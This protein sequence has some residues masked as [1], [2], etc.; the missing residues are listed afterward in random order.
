MEFPVLGVDLEKLTFYYLI[1]QEDNETI[2]TIESDLREH[3][4]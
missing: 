4:N 2:L 1:Q 3:P